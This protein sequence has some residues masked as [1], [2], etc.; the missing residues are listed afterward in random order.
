[1]DKN[2]VSKGN[3]LGMIQELLALSNVGTNRL[4]LNCGEGGFKRDYNVVGNKDDL[5]GFM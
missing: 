5:N 3:R 4:R 1:M 2:I